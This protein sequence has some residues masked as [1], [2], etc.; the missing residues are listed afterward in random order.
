MIDVKIDG[1]WIG[2]QLEEDRHVLGV[3]VAPQIH[4]QSPF[5][6][7][8]VHGNTIEWLP[9]LLPLAV[10]INHYLEP[11]EGGNGPLSN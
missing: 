1:V 9:L 3:S 2:K 11:L 6:L 7:L 5:A 8:V 4:Y 10:A